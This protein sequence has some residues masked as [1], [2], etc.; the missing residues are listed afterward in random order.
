MAV[1]AVSMDEEQPG[2][3]WSWLLCIHPY[4]SDCH[5]RRSLGLATSNSILCITFM[6]FSLVLEAF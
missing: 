3:V 1:T 6:A 4:C 5:A 2:A